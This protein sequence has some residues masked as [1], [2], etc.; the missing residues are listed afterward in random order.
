MNCEEQAR[1]LVTEKCLIATDADQTILA[2]TPNREEEKLVFFRRMAPQLVEAARLGAHIGFI[3][4]NS[5]H[6]LCS[7]FLDSLIEQLCH[8]GDLAVITRFHFFC[9]SGGVYFH[10]PE[11]A[12]EGAAR[13]AAKVERGERL[14]RCFWHAITFSKNKELSIQ[15]QFV[16]TGYVERCLIAPGDAQLIENILRE[17]AAEYML[18]LQRNRKLYDQKYDLDW[19]SEKDGSIKVP[20]AEVRAAAYRNGTLEKGATVQ[21]T[22]KPV[23]SFRQAR[24]DYA[25]ELFG[26]DLRSQVVHQIQEKIDRA[27]LGLYV[28]RPGGRASIDVTLERLDKAY[29]LE[30]LI[31]HLRLQGNT[32]RRQQFGANTIYFGD[33]VMVGGGNDYPVTRIPG[34]LVF[35]VNR[36]RGLVPFLRDVVVP[37]AIFEGPEAT[38]DVLTQFNQCARRLLKGFQPDHSRKTAIEALKEELFATRISEKI[39]HLRAGETSVDDW[40]TLHTFVTLMARDQGCGRQSLSLLVKELETIMGQFAAR[41]GE[42]MPIPVVGHSEA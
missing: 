39:A 18:E 25:R 21:I 13:R 12:V 3:T 6:E 1:R 31:D 41:S 42:A 37:S 5:M 32:H 28:A 23:L 36:D 27:G 7:R 24:E 16:D 9:N 34:L 17:T 22:L 19:L 11:S 4:G 14:R 40:Q 29:A 15:P 30:F 10:F 26:K 2:Q 33:E 38:A 8:T 35:A 20:T